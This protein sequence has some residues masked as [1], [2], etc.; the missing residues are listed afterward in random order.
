M[1][2]QHY[3]A[4]AFVVSGARAKCIFVGNLV[5]QN[6]STYLYLS[7]AQHPFILLIFKFLNFSQQNLNFS[8]DSLG[9]MQIYRLLTITR[10]TTMKNCSKRYSCLIVTTVPHKA[11]GQ[12]FIVFVLL[13]N[14]ML[15]SFDRA[16]S[17]LLC[18]PFPLLLRI[19]GG[20]N[21]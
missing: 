13:L 20:Y 21:M 11:T 14:K 15:D 4:L 3:D 12:F 17:S 6:A 10:A 16:P 1:L 9:F 5:S 7:N 8:D 19:H 2:P 18:L